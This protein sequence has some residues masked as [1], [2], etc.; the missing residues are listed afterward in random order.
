MISVFLRGQFGNTLFELATAK[1]LSEINNCEFIG[2]IYQLSIENRYKDII[3]TFPEV[4]NQF[5]NVHDIYV[6][7][8]YQIINE[9]NYENILYIN[10]SQLLV[11]R[12]YFQDMKYWNY[13][14]DWCKK[15]FNI[16]PIYSDSLGIHLR[17]NEYN[18]HYS[19]FINH[20]LIDFCNKFNN[21]KILIF[22]DNNDIFINNYSHIIEELPANVTIIN[23]DTNTE[24]RMLA[25][26]SYIAMGL[27]T[28][29][30]WASYLGNPQKIFYY[31]ESYKF[32]EKIRNFSKTL[33]FMDIEII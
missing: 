33:K 31:A 15:L 24:F 30:W 10:N 4:Y 21:M 1:Y 18:K 13:D 28:W 32:I 27:S 20:R 29:S 2:Y 9:N 19:D 25:G 11:L 5:N 23:K 14:R 7:S 8:D 3:A 12:D 22:T 16:E 17:L 6:D 26:C